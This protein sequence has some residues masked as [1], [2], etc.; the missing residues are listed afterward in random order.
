MIKHRKLKLKGPLITLVG[1]L[2]SVSSLVAC[3]E[4]N[5]NHPSKSSG[6]QP[7]QDPPG[8]GGG[9]GTA[10]GAPGSGG[11]ETTTGPLLHP[12]PG[13]EECEHAP[14]EAECSGGWCRL[15]AGCFVMGSPIT[16]WRRGRDTEDQVA[17][18]F[19]SDKLVQQHE[20]SRGDFK[21]LYGTAVPTE[22]GCLEDSCPL[23]FLSFWDALTL[24]D[25]LS[26]K[27]G[28]APCYE[29]EGCTGTLG[30]SLSCNQVTAPE[31]SVYGC[32]GY[33]LM[34][35]AEAEY[36]VRAGTISEYYSGRIT[37][38][39]NYNCNPDQAL[40]QIAWYC[41]NSGSKVHPAAGLEPN[42]FGLYDLLGNATERLNE[43][44]HYLSSPGGTDPN[45]AV[46]TVGTTS[47]SIVLQGYIATNSQLRAASKLSIPR[48]Y[49]GERQGTRLI[50]TL[51]SPD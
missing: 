13:F 18:T 35:A 7:D 38:Y 37:E 31:K 34:T 6:G 49:R 22:E 4:K 42:G 19:S 46:G 33:R 11:S 43:E 3:Q 5:S 14:V 1:V 48:A 12:P 39:S 25:D 26:K 44:K 41:H 20:F 9:D 23:T 50:R 32:E 21:A 29:P 2:V 27:E 8:D 40:A 28:F 51:P 15:P 45:G 17:V 36:A 30:V 47:D 10:G 24:A 16:E